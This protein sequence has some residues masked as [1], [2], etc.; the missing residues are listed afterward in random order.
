MNV[1]GRH[2]EGSYRTLHKYGKV[3][4]CVEIPEQ[5]VRLFHVSTNRSVWIDPWRL[6]L[7]ALPLNNE[8]LHTFTPAK[9]TDFRNQDK[10]HLSSKLSSLLLQQRLPEQAG[11]DA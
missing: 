6:L 3:V 4:V 5:P 7:A 8:S 11:T 9:F 1:V 2:R 10:S